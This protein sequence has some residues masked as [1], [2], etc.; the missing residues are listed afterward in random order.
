M[1]LAM[2]SRD[3]AAPTGPNGGA[4][5]PTTPKFSASRGSPSMKRV[6]ASALIVGVSL[7]L[8]GCGEES[9]TESSTTT[10]T[11]AGSTTETTTQ[12]VEKSGENPPP[13]TGETTPPK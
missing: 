7:C 10:T 4:G 6:L 2:I 1:A 8:A 3:F 12:K 5:P 11:P 13:A 9:K